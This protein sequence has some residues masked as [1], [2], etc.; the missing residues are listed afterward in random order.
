MFVVFA[1][2]RWQYHLTVVLSC[3]SDES[4]S[5]D[6]DGNDVEDSTGKD[7]A[8]S[9]SIVSKF[10]R[11]SKARFLKRNL[12]LES[13][14]DEKE[15]ADLMPRRN[16]SCR[17]RREKHEAIDDDEKED[18]DN[19]HDHDDHA[20]VDDDDGVG[21]DDDDKSDD[22]SIDELGGLARRRVKGPAKRASGGARRKLPKK[23]KQS[24]TREASDGLLSSAMVAAG[25]IHGINY[26][27]TS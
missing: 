23:P 9:S 18:D 8:G 17:R 6:N 5:A 26:Q 19:D 21:D 20:V 16:R 14:E 24:L 25:D 15:E 27:G 3:K 2:T 12:E 13:E 1:F 22:G 7:A 10:G 4:I 11:R